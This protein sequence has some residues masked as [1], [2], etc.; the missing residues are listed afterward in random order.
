MQPP[1]PPPPNLQTLSLRTIENIRAYLLTG[2]VPSFAKLASKHDRKVA[3]GHFRRDAR[4]FCIPKQGA[5]KWE[6]CKSEAQ[7]QRTKRALFSS[8]LFCN[9]AVGRGGE[10]A[11]SKESDKH[12][13]ASVKEPSSGDSGTPTGN[14]DTDRSCLL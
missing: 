10:A 11:Q 9:S 14:S 3:A 5:L 8:S 4:Q 6:L 1:P 12:T 13:G 7:M 2:T